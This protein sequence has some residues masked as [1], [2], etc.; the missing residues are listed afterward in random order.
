MGLQSS[1]V[2]RSRHLRAFPIAKHRVRCQA[3]AQKRRASQGAQVA[4]MR[5]AAGG[6]RWLC[7]T[8]GRTAESISTCMPRLLPHIWHK[9]IVVFHAPMMMSGMPDQEAAN[10]TTAGCLCT[11]TSGHQTHPRVDAESRKLL[12][13][14]VETAERPALSGRRDCPNR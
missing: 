11:A 9:D 12:S 5:C 14:H 7:K 1:T 2:A 3:V 10:A 6:H 13:A 8:Q 4:L